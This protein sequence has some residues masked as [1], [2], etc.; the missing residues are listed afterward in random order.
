MAT[1]SVTE[2]HREGEHSHSSTDRLAAAESR[3]YGPLHIGILVQSGAPSLPDSDTDHGA[4]PPGLLYHG[5]C[6][7][8][9]IASC[10][11]SRAG[12]WQQHPLIMGT[13]LRDCLHE[14][15]ATPPRLPLRYLCIP[16]CCTRLLR[17]IHFGCIGSHRAFVRCKLTTS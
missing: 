6:T 3:H 11:G 4:A 10:A 8:S 7:C 2:P 13:W 16:P 9:G 1:G 17:N 5:W 14:C 12:P 15:A